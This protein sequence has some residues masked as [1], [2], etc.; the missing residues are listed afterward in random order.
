MRFGKPGGKAAKH[1]A[2]K[3]ANDN[4]DD[5]SNSSSKSDTSEPANAANRGNPAVRNAIQ[6]EWFRWRPVGG[7]VRIFQRAPTKSQDGRRHYRPKPGVLALKVVGVWIDL[8]QSSMCQIISSDHD[9]SRIQRVQVVGKCMLSSPG[10]I[11]GL[12]RGTLWGLHPRMYPWQTGY[13]HMHVAMHIRGE[14]DKYAGSYKITQ[15]PSSSKTIE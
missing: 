3:H 9:C 15:N 5:S 12:S 1:L 8:F 6:A 7:K 14:W 11:W 10:R 13:S 4:D 2:V